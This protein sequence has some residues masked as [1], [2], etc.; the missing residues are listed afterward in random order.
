VSMPEIVM[1]LVSGAWHGVK[2][3]T[4]GTIIEERTT[5]ELAWVKI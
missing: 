5:D 2:R 4:H 1:A 3:Q